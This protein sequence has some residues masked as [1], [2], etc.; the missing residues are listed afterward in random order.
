MAKLFIGTW[1]TG[2]KT[3]F[4]INFQNDAFTLET[5]LVFNRLAKKEDFENFDWV[6]RFQKF[7][8]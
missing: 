1:K 3:D 2:G 5:F 6:H 4:P 7:L 8:F